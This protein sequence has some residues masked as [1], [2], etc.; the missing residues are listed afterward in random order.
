MGI[1]YLF[2]IADLFIVAYLFWYLA[3]CVRQSAEGE[4]RA[5]SAIASSEQP[6]DMFLQMFRTFV[7]VLLAAVPAGA[8]FVYTR[9]ADATFWLILG[10]GVLFLPMALLAVTMFDSLGGLNPLLIIGSM[11]STFFPYLGLVTAWYIVA[12]LVVGLWIYLGQSRMFLVVLL[13]VWATAY[14]FMVNAHLLGRF[15][16]RNQEK[17]NW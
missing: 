16:Y 12:A 3:E 14:L 15:Y 4:I 1:A 8:Y 6:W 11:I 17:L 13:L 5:P 7:C 2:F 9:Q 10:A